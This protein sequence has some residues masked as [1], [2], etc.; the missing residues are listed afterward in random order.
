MERNRT[1][2]IKI[3]LVTTLL[4]LCIFYPVL[5]NPGEVKLVITGFETNQGQV[6][7]KGYN[8]PEGF[9]RDDDLA[10]RIYKENVEDL[11]C[12]LAIDLPAGEYAILVIH[13]ENSNELL[14]TNF[15]GMPKEPVGVSINPKKSKPDYVKSK[16]TVTGSSSLTLNIVVDTIF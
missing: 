3:R 7:I 10:Y 8:G 5:A 16:F 11:E 14:D 2:I 15:I 6:I 13:D 9:A 4:M 1:L 12:H